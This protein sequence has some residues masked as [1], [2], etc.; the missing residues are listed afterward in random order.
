MSSSPRSP[1][2]PDRASRARIGASASGLVLTLLLANQSAARAAP[3]PLPYL[4]RSSPA[5]L[6]FA[7]AR[8]PTPPPPPPEKPEARNPDPAAAPATLAGPGDEAPATTPPATAETAP[9]RTAGDAAARP[10]APEGLPIIPD[11]YAPSAPVSIEDLLPYFTLPP[12]PASR[13]TYE[14]K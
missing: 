9:P 14:V 7:T 3:E 11:G 6:R 8:M 5:A 4:V 10:A 2:A 13:A 12:K 1:S